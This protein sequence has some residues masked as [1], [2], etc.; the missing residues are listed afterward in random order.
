MKVGHCYYDDYFK[1]STKVPIYLL[2]AVPLIILTILFQIS[3]LIQSFIKLGSTF[4][5]TEFSSTYNIL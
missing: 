5:Q 2:L 3:K 4:W 1:V